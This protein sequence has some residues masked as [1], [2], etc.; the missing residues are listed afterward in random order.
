MWGQQITWSDLYHSAAL[1]LFTTDPS[2]AAKSLGEAEHAG[3][4]LL[5]IAL[6]AFDNVNHLSLKVTPHYATGMQD[7]WTPL[8][9][10][11]KLQTWFAA[12]TTPVPLLLR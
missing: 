6:A 5:P 11:N 2:Q 3:L 9:Q 12:V 7:S 1:H 10:S 4:W 8:E